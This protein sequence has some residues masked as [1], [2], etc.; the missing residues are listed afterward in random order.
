MNEVTLW[1]KNPELEKAYVTKRDTSVK[2]YII[3]AFVIFVFIAAVQ[4][5][6]FSKYVKLFFETTVTFEL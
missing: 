6:T 4:L 5:I 1:F 3:C 2:F